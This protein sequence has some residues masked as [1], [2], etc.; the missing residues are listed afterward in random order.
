[1]LYLK[2]GLIYMIERHGFIPKMRPS[3]M[4]S[5]IVFRESTEPYCSFVQNCLEVHIYMAIESQEM[6]TYPSTGSRN[7]IQSNITARRYN[8]QLL[9]CPMFSNVTRHP[10]TMVNCLNRETINQ[11][12]HWQLFLVRY[13]Y[14]GNVYH[15]RAT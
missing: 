3:K 4:K 1:M 2:R 11:S 8:R 7:S 9:H 13:R 5:F 12:P 14:K 10:I 15:A 6:N